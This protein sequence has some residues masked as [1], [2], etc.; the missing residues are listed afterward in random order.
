MGAEK[1]KERAIGLTCVESA[2]SVCVLL[3]P[4]HRQIM[5]IYDVTYSSWREVTDLIWGQGFGQRS[6]QVKH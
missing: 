3:G 1:V 2:V 4:V 6:P 5:L